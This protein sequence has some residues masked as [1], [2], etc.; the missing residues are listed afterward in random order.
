MEKAITSNGSMI[1]RVPCLI[2]IRV[3]YQNKR[4]LSREVETMEKSALKV[5][6]DAQDN[7]IVNQLWSRH[8]LLHL[9][10]CI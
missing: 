3:G 9:M 6:K 7:N 5:L 4:R 2:S 10:N 8:K 1:S